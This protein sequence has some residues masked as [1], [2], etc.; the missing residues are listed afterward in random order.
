MCRES[1]WQDDALGKGCRHCMR[2]RKGS[3]HKS[4]GLKKKEGGGER[5]TG[6][7]QGSIISLK[8]V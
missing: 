1:T 6:K 7:I 5:L 3:R 4:K 2:F 8:T